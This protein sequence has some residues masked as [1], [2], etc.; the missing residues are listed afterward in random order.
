MSETAEPALTEPPLA[1]LSLAEPSLVEPSL[2]ASSDRGASSAAPFGAA[3]RGDSLRVLAWLDSGGHVDARGGR[4]LATMIMK[5]SA[6]GHTALVEQLIQRGA[7]V[8]L[9]DEQG[10][11]ALHAA[12]F[13]GD[14]PTVVVLLEAGA[15]SQLG[16]MDGETALDWAEEK[17]HPTIIE[18]LRARS[19][20]PRILK[21]VLSP[22]EI[23]RIVELG[24]VVTPHPIR[25]DASGHEVAFLHAGGATS[26]LAWHC[27]GLLATLISRMRAGDPG[28]APV[29]TSLNVR[30]IE[31]HTY[32]TG[33]GLIGGEHRNHRDSGSILSMSVMLSDPEA[34]TGGEFLTWDHAEARVPHHVAQGDGVLFR[35]EQCHNVAVVTS[36][37][38]RTLVIE[39]WTG[40]TNVKDRES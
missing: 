5:A 17:G 21:G 36:G 34:M 12:A 37:M 39:L 15:R 9:Q 6:R 31:L 1:G 8:N 22:Q 24:D 18:L 35:S 14:Q 3:G 27:A 4:A 28:W 11:T 26:L 20:G 38:R 40:P 23:L 25:S 33:G 10:S 30:C 13:M 16:N 32:V 2:G 29:A 19:V 7:N